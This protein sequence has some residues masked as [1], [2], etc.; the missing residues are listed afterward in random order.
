MAVTVWT[1]TNPT[2]LPDAVSS[3]FLP[4]SAHGALTGAI[5]P[6]LYTTAL[7]LVDPESAARITRFHRRPDACSESPI[8]RRAH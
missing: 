7:S 8:S 1:I 6:K 4:L 2:S 3:V 5:P